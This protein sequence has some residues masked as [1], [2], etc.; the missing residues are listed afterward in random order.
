[1]PE[2]QVSRPNELRSRLPWKHY[3]IGTLI[4]GSESVPRQQSKPALSMTQLTTIH[5]DKF[6]D[7]PEYPCLQDQEVEEKKNKTRRS[8]RLKRVW[9]ATKR[10]LKTLACGCH[11]R[12]C[13]SRSCVEIGAKGRTNQSGA[14][15]VPEVEVLN[16]EGVMTL[17]AVIVAKEERAKACESLLTVHQ[18]HGDQGEATGPKNID[19]DGVCPIESKETVLTASKESNA[20]EVCQGTDVCVE[21]LTEDSTKGNSGWSLPSEEARHKGN[22]N[23]NLTEDGQDVQALLLSIMFEEIVTLLNHT[24]YLQALEVAAIKTKERSRVEEGDVNNIQSSCSIDALL[25]GI[26]VEE[27]KNEWDR[28]NYCHTYAKEIE[29]NRAPKGKEID[30][31][32]APKSR[33]VEEESLGTIKPFQL[34]IKMFET[35]K[36]LTRL[37]GRRVVKKDSSRNNNDHPGAIVTRT[38]DPVRA[39]AA[40][41][42]LKD[43]NDLLQKMRNISISESLRHESDNQHIPD[44]EVL[45]TDVFL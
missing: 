13:M 20:Y 8:C 2:S 33:Y 27:L 36:E 45:K 41:T 29:M 22:D 21:D 26:K 28:M 5:Q 40:A 44:S 19:E 18:E 9:H 15:L 42:A 3:E 37:A 24:I 16:D 30:M 31:N 35:M 10:A 1:M 14:D 39:L 4:N 17:G 34:N 23:N 12:H 43:D 7:Y 32:K 11:Q 6:K 38:I 25:V